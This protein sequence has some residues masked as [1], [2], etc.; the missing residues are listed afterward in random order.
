[1]RL[2]KAQAR[3]RLAEAWA[4]FRTVFSYSKEY[5]LTAKDMEVIDRVIKKATN[6]LK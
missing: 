1:M 6:K 2:S 5:P 4:K 3:K